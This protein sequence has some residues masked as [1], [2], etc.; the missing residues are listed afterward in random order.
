MKIPIDVKAIRTALG[1]TQEAF[2]RRFG[3]DQA[4]IHR[5]ESLGIPEH[6]AARAVM[7][8]F[9]ADL[10]QFTAQGAAE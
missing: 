2:G 6:G 9:V 4:T 3:V 1:E 5:W 10:Q 7:E 8:R